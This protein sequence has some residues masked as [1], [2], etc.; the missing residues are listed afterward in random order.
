MNEWITS[1]DETLGP[2]RGVNCYYQNM[3]CK[4]SKQRQQPSSISQVFEKIPN[5]RLT[6]LIQPDIHPFCKSL[7]LC[8]QTFNCNDVNKY[9]QLSCTIFKALQFQYCT[10]PKKQFVERWQGAGL[11]EFLVCYY[12]YYYHYCYR[13]YHYYYYHQDYSYYYLRLRC[14]GILRQFM[15]IHVN[16]GAQYSSSFSSAGVQVQFLFV[17]F[18]CRQ[19]SESM[20]VE[21]LLPRLSV[22]RS[23]VT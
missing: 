18:C 1:G 8:V 22:N 16:G 6:R 11:S 4:K 10:I 7:L 19:H 15:S 21:V 12:H 23:A 5:H 9:Q 13:H 14:H 2:V 3:A 20:A 17:Q